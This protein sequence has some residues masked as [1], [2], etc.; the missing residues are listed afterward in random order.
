MRRMER[1]FI[2]VGLEGYRGGLVSAVARKG[3]AKL[4]ISY[5]SAKSPANAGNSC[6]LHHDAHAMHEPEFLNA[7]NAGMFPGLLG[8]ILYP[9]SAP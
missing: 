6:T 8:I 2:H 9:R 3:Y 4:R 1:R 5:V 7:R